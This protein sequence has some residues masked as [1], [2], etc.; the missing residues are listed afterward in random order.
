[1]IW[2]VSWPVPYAGG[3]RAR[4][5]HCLAAGSQWLRRSPQPRRVGRRGTCR[6][7]PTAAR[8]SPAWVRDRAAPA[9]R[10]SRV[11]KPR[12]FVPGAS[13]ASTQGLAG[14]PPLAVAS[15]ALFQVFARFPKLPR[16]RCSQGRG[17]ICWSPSSAARRKSRLRLAQILFGAG[18]LPPGA[19]RATQAVQPPRHQW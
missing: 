1:M 3:S 5:A 11:W 14:R 13:A 15:A 18:G 2:R 9:A 8:A 17:G 10:P 16:E 7:A 6:P 12:L 4:H 19:Q